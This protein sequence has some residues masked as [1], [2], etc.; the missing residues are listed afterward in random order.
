[1]ILN[2]SIALRVRSRK[3][4]AVGFAAWLI[5]SQLCGGCKDTSKSDYSM[6][7]MGSCNQQASIRIIDETNGIASYARMDNSP[8]ALPFKNYVNTISKYVF[9]RID[10]M[11]ECKGNWQDDP[12]VELTF[13]YRPLLKCKGVPFN[14]EQTQSDDSKQLNSPWVKISM[15]RSPK[16]IV[17]AAFL[18][19]ERQF[20]FDQ[21]IRS[22]PQIVPIK[23][24]LSLESDIY[25][26]FADDYEKNVLLLFS[27]KSRDTAVANISKRLPADILWLFSHSRSFEGTLQPGMQETVEK[28]KETYINLTKTLLNLRFGSA[29]KEQNYQSVLDIQ[30]R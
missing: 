2:T 30:Y 14:F 9:T 24:L 15:S 11:G 17:R 22:D 1:M 23:P 12:Q 28:G 3:S 20:L 27:Q 5:L 8:S 6:K 19:N 16:L 25:S 7:T 13:I 21:A 10:E 29:Q 18:W 26:K 4:I